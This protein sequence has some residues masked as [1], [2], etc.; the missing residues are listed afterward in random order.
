MSPKRGQRGELSYRFAAD[1]AAAGTVRDALEADVEGI[2]WGARLTVALLARAI[3][4]MCVRG[5]G[6]AVCVEVSIGSERARVEV[7]G[8][9]RGFKLPLS[10]RAIDYF[11]FDEEAPR[12]PGW[13]AYLL[14]QLADEWGVDEDAGVAWFEVDHAT[15]VARRLQA[16]DQLLRAGSA[17]R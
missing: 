14:D 6:G 16:S 8:T 1:Q 15:S 13:R 17:S 9:G 10:P 2:E 3:V 4:A 11:S 5:E 12:P 7:S